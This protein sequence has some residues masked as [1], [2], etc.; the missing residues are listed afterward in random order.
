MA[1][2]WQYI[3]LFFFLQETLER[4][5]EVFWEPWGSLS[6]AT[7]SIICTECDAQ[8]LSNQK[9][10]ILAFSMLTR[11]GFT[12]GEASHF[13]SSPP[14]RQHRGHRKRR[15]RRLR[16]RERWIRWRKS[17]IRDQCI[18]VCMRVYLSGC[19]ER[20][21]TGDFPWGLQTGK[22]GV[23]NFTLTYLASV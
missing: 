20:A 6:R 23:I 5:I 18:S 19:V 12:E 17:E 22:Q 13:L 11:V 3:M 9:N 10:K 2:E 15:R 7:D 16:E 14:E 1:N 4:I 21:F 8:S